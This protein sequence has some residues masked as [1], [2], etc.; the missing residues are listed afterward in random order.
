LA[1]QIHC[2][3]DSGSDLRLLRNQLVGCSGKIKLRDV[4]SA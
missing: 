3:E 1:V 2:D 4:H